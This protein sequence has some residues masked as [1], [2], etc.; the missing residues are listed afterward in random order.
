M[1]KTTGVRTKGRER[2]VVAERHKRQQQIWIL[3]VA[4][5]S[6]FISMVLTAASSDVLKEAEIFTAFLSSL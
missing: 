5:I 4:V 2:E 3:T 6:F 1:R